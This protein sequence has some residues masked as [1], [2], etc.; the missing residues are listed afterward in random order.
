MAGPYT[1]QNKVPLITKGGN[2]VLAL[3]VKQ[4]KL[5]YERDAEIKTREALLEAKLAKD[6]MVDSMKIQKSVK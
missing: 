5:F 6:S 3:V 4:R 1:P 2:T